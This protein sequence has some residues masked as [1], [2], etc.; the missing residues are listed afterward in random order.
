MTVRRIG[1]CAFRRNMRF[2]LRRQSLGEEIRVTRLGRVVQ[3]LYGMR[4]RL[5]P[6][7]RPLSGC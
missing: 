4:R 1:Y 6:L 2:W 3:I 5:N 7:G